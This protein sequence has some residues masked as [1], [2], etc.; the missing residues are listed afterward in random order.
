MTS[1]SESGEADVTPT[2]QGGSEGTPKVAAP[3]GKLGDAPGTAGLQVKLRAV[4]RKLEV[5]EQALAVLNRRLLQLERGENG[6]GGIARALGS[7]YVR[8]QDL[9]AEVESDEAQ[10]QRLS[11]ALASGESRIQALSAEVASLR[12]ANHA[13]QQELF[14]LRNSRVYRWSGPVRNAYHKVRR[15]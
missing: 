2:S 3:R 9:S 10:I 12:E 1:G 6:V 14:W 15:R 13:L 4:K 8:I 11:A 7:E 5:R